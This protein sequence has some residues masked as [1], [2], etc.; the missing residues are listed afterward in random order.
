MPFILVDD[1]D[2]GVTT[3]DAMKCITVAFN[4]QVKA[5]VQEA[6]DAALHI[7]NPS[8]LKVCRLTGRIV[9]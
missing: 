1:F 7:K 3:D 6:V 9:D 4:E 5:I 8:G 2:S